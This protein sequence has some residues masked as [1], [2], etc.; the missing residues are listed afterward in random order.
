MTTLPDLRVELSDEVG[1]ILAQD[2]GVTATKTNTVP[3]SNDGAI[4]F[5]NLDAKTQA[6]KLI[7]TC[8]L[9][10]DI[11]RSTELSITHKPQTVAKLYSAFVRAM[12]KCARHYGGHVRG[13]IGDRVMVIFDCNDCFRKAVDCAILMNS[14]AQYVINKHFT[15][16]EVKCGIGIDTGKM[17]VTKT[18]FRRRGVEQHNYKNLG[19]GPINWI[20]L[21]R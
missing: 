12:T 21:T 9:Y 7:D 18:G 14:T 4:T 3:H 16:N 5:P 2:F 6:C 17:L 8:V 1:T 15:R 11:R 10:I 13:I 20:E 19:S